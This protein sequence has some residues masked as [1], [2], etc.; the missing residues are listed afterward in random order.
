MSKYQYDLDV[1]IEADSEVAADEIIAKMAAIKGVI[2][3]ES[4]DGPNEVEEPVEDEDE[5]VS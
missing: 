3:C 5:V 4:D 1:T 2:E